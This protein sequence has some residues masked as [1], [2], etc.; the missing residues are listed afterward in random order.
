MRLPT[1]AIQ[2]R[3]NRTKPPSAVSPQNAANVIV[4]DHVTVNQ[5]HALAF[6]LV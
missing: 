6:G 5:L 2:I 4:L 3:F 1:L